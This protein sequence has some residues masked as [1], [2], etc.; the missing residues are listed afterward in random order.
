MVSLMT[1]FFGVLCK[2]SRGYKFIKPAVSGSSGLP[3]R[4]FET[5]GF[6][7][8]RREI[9]E[10]MVPCESCGSSCLNGQGCL[11]QSQGSSRTPKGLLQYGALAGA[12][13]ISSHFS[14]QSRSFSSAKEN[15][16]EQ[17]VDVLKTAKNTSTKY[18]RLDDL[19]ELVKALES[20]LVRS[21]GNSKFLSVPQLVLREL[22]FRAFT[23]IMHFLRSEHLE[24]LKRV[25]DDPEASDNDKFVSMQLIKNACIAAG[26]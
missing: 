20:G 4:R 21:D 19:S 18:T 12:A 13:G 14:E 7:R 22:T 23:E 5:N 26:R 11:E 1:G 25:L 8:K 17:Y 9:D 6:V 2:R 3:S 10:K 16:L 24:Q 15:G